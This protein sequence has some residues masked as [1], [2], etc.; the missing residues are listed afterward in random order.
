MTKVFSAVR[1]LWSRLVP[2]FAR[3]AYR[4][5]HLHV[6][7]KGLKLL[8][9]LLAFL[10]FVVSRQPMREVLLVGVPI[11]YSNIRDHVEISSEVPATANVRLRGPQDVVR[12]I[13]SNQMEV[14]ADLSNRAPGVRSIQ[15]KPAEGGPRNVQVLRIEP[16][17]VELRLEPTERKRV[18]VVAR[19]TGNPAPGF[20]LYNSSV[21]PATAEV[22]GPAS[23][24]AEVARVLTESVPLD[25]RREGFT[26]NVDLDL[27]RQGVRLVTA[28]PFRL[29]AQIGE[30]RLERVFSDVPVVWPDR[31]PHGRLLTPHVKV[32]L[33]GPR[34]MVESMNPQDLKAEIYTA[35]VPSIVEHLTPNI[36]WP[37]ALGA[38]LEVVSV[39]P[40]EVTVKR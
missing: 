22:E 26:T 9:V 4:L 5:R 2:D 11:V 23:R 39:S 8:S 38:N 40:K 32:T 19:F 16:A 10:L 6:E 33:R 28:G 20:E 31:P 17:S 37:A 21:E 3:L 35:N 27:H 18:P 7:N 13:T 36:V 14:V 12:S 24:V 34:K 15:L 30:Q 1:Q 25:G 29:T